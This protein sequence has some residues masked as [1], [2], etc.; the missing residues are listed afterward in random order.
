MKKDNKENRTKIGRLKKLNYDTK[1]TNRIR[2]FRK[3]IR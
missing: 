1:T 3:P 2:G